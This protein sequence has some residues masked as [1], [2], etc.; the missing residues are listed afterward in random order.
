MV[1][2]AYREC[3]GVERGRKATVVFLARYSPLAFAAFLAACSTTLTS[4]DFQFE[5]LYPD[6]PAEQSAVIAGFYELQQGGLVTNTYGT[7]ITAVNGRA[8]KTHAALSLEAGSHL[9]SLSYASPV[10]G[11]TA[12]GDLSVSLEAGKRYVVRGVEDGAVSRKVFFLLQDVD[13]A[14]VRSELP[15]RIETALAENP[16]TGLLQHFA[17]AFSE[18]AE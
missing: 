1:G 6:V 5:D 10:S 14:E 13:T 18:V 15:F 12:T 4:P 11:G 9:L 7:V 3:Q 16:R 2:R 17:A 8:T